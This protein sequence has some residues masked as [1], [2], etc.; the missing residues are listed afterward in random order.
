MGS[1]LSTRPSGKLAK[2]QLRAHFKN[3][4][5]AF[6]QLTFLDFYLH[7]ITGIWSNIP[8]TKFT[9]SNFLS[10]KNN[11]P[12]QNRLSFLIDCKSAI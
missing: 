3:C 1:S 5:F 2:H 4:F 8:F 6:R 7:C 9:V 12:I 10:R 11:E